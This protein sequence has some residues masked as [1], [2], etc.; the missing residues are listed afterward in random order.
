M[1]FTRVGF[2]VFKFVRIY[3]NTVILVHINLTNQC[4]INHMFWNNK[5]CWMTNCDG[6]NGP[7]GKYP[8]AY[9]F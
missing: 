1:D 3:Q 5:F 2:K 8:Q 4:F 6:D 7:A 9:L